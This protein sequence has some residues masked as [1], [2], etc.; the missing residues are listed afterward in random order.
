MPCR[1]VWSIQGDESATHCA[2]QLAAQN[3]HQTLSTT[4]HAE[5]GSLSCRLTG[6]CRQMHKMR[7]S[8][9]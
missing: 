1:A 5:S 3:A 9:Y 8:V 4:T 2:V 7:W 6:N